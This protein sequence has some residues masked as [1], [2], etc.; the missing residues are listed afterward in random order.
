MIS[1]RHMSVSLI[2]TAAT[3][4]ASMESVGITL[5]TQYKEA[6]RGTKSNPD[7]M[8]KAAKKRERK[9]RNRLKNSSVVSGGI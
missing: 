7:K 4:A 6:P 8:D 1:N 3:L 2:A 9:N 5:G